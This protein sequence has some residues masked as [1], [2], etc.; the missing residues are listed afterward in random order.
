[1]LI[2]EAKTS[3]TWVYVRHTAKRKR[4]QEIAEE[5]RARVREGK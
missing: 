3:N 1:L 4:I 2:G 5:A